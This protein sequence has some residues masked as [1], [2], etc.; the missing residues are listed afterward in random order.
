MSSPSEPSIITELKPSWMERWQTAGEVPWS[1]CMTHRDVR[2][3]LDGGEDQVAQEGGTRVLA[4]TG[5]GLD[6][7]RGV[8]LVGGLHDGAHLLE[9]V[10][11]ERRDAVL[12]LGGVVQQLAHADQGHRNFLSVAVSVSRRGE[13]IGRRSRRRATRARP[14]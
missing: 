9:V 10:D 2:E 11:V 5:G 7:D 14:Q 13:G 12:M 4:G 3:L 1:W 8:G 6:D